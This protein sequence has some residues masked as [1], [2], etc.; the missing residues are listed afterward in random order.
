LGFSLLFLLL[1]LLIFRGV[2]SRSKSFIKWPTIAF[3]LLLAGR[4]LLEIAIQVEDNPPP[5]PPPITPTTTT[6]RSH[7]PLRPHLGGLDVD[8]AVS[9]AVGIYIF[10]L[11]VYNHS[12][13]FS[14]EEEDEE[15]GS[16]L[17]PNTIV[18]NPLFETSPHQLTTP[19]LLHS[20]GGGDGV[21]VG[22]GGGKVDAV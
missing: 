13:E 12:L 3:T 16:R 9:A 19:L 20:N 7:L 10:V 8:P 1:G 11:F 15:G 2:E 17:V 14:H 4:F 21:M 5:P 6:R 22:M 18:M